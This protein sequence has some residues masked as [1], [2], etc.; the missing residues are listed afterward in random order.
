[1]STE[2][3]PTS[4]MTAIEAAG[5]VANKYAAASAFAKYTAGKSDNTLDAQRADLATFGE[6]L[7]DATGGRDCPTA[8]QLQTD[9]NA[10]RGMTH[11]LVAAFAEWLLQHGY[12]MASINRK[13]STVRVYA[14]LAGDA[15][16][17]STDET[18]LIR[19]V[20]GYGGKEGKR[21]DERRKEAGQATRTGS[22]K[23]QHVRLEP[24]HVKALKTQ[25]DT[26]Q[27]RRDAVIMA[28]LLDHG[29]RVGELAGLPVKGQVVTGEGVKDVG[30]F[31]GKNKQG[32]LV[33]RF[34]FYRPKVD[35]VQTH[36]LTN[37]ALTAVA[38]WMDTDA[39]VMGPLLRGSRKG[40]HL[41][42]AGMSERAITE[43]VRDLGEAIGV[44]G[45]SAHDCRHSW[46]TRA[47]KGGTDAFKLRDAG[48]WNSL[49]MPSR[50]VEAAAVAN[51][52]VNL[53]D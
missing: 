2:L 4:G 25:P 49:A 20:R 48:G 15:E 7:C 11:G 9:P 24:E 19:S 51:A 53:E 8:A 50:Y 38:R 39:P 29:L 5:H 34:V 30:V 16:V 12:S 45:L 10:W 41:T 1:M 17:I 28:L 13:L 46:A 47:V 27:G 42:G 22:K 43:R 52:G 21:V 40:G 35:R 44:H 3:V 18:T 26:P 36:T 6:Y 32:E 14:K 33:G 23:A 37:G 31:L